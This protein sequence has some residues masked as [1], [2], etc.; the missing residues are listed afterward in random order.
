MIM[1]TRSPVFLVFFTGEV[2][3]Q[4]EWLTEMGNIFGGGGR[5]L[6]WIHIDTDADEFQ[7][8]DQVKVGGYE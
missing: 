8:G 7:E 5:L 3:D 4:R 2:R 1:S 6:E